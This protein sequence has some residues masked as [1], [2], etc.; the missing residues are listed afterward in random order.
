MILRFTYDN[1]GQGLLAEPDEIQQIVIH[2]RQIGSLLRQYADDILLL[3]GLFI[4]SWGRDAQLQ[5]F[6]KRKITAVSA[7]AS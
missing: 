5:V 1:T 4:G 6:V 3:Q 2:I 7:N